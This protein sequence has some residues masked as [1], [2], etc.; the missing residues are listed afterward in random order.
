MYIPPQP[1]RE[2]PE[3]HTVQNGTPGHTH[4]RHFD[5]KYETFNI[6]MKGRIPELTFFPFVFFFEDFF[7]SFSDFITSVLSFSFIALDWSGDLIP[8]KMLSLEEGDL[9]FLGLVGLGDVSSDPSPVCTVSKQGLVQVLSN[10]K[11]S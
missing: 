1:C 3:W 6:A 4:V 7:V 11:S 10:R 9:L 8:A 2:L 5:A